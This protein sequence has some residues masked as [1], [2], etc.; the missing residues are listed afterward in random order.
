M[1]YFEVLGVPTDASAADIKR[2]YRK[3]ARETHPDTCEFL[4]VD[5]EFD[6]VRKAYDV[7]SDPQSRA[8]YT[9]FGMLNPEYKKA[10]EKLQESAVG[11]VKNIAPGY[12]IDL[13]AQL[14]QNVKAHIKLLYKDKQIV[15]DKSK[16]YAYYQRKIKTKSKSCRN[17]FTEGFSRVQ[18]NIDKQ[19]SLLDSKIK[20]GD[21]MLELLDFYEFENLQFFPYYDACSV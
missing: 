10:I 16:Q 8:E 5:G 2:A 14:K 18:K 3:R 12:S 7:L 15:I 20:T 19:L 4:I 11:I 21:K 13:I 6:A 9:K 1:N 17:V